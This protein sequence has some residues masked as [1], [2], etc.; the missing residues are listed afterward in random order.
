MPLTSKFR[1]LLKSWLT[2]P[3][4]GSSKENGKIVK[5]IPTKGVPQGSII[6]PICCNFVLDG[7]QDHMEQA[8]EKSV[9]RLT[10]KEITFLTKKLET[11]PTYKRINPSVKLFCMRYVD[12]ILIFGKFSWDQSRS[13]QSALET[14]LIDRGLKIKDSISKTFIAFKPGTSF[15]YLNFKFVFPNIKASK[16][17]HGRFTKRKV[18]PTTAGWISMSRKN[19]SVPFI[20]I[21]PDRYI[22][23]KST[24]REQL[25]RKNI[26]LSVGIMIEKLNQILRGAMN[27]YSVT[28]T[29][30]R[31][32]SPL[33]NFIHKR[34]YKYLLS[35][36][37][38]KPKVYT[39]IKKNFIVKSHFISL[40]GKT[41]LNI[42][43]IRP[44][45]GRH[46][47]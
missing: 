45:G 2:A 5:E 34:F 47:P 4:I 22:R 9:Y 33:N 18:T 12:D 35:K 1:H 32:V 39:Y 41:L 15:K 11:N 13:L 24:L 36:Y 43:N 40:E 38:S 25:S 46:L 37:S 20:I 7:L 29:I 21:D 17:N 8:F 16:L 26:P 31:Q 19:R 28:E 27:Y 10:D 14:F 6:G 44:Y 42:K 30:R 3:L 23:I